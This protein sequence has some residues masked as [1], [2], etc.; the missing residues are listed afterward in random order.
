M[1]AFVRAFLLG[2]SSCLVGFLM[3]LAAHAEGIPRCAPEASM[4]ATLAASYGERPMWLGVAQ[5]DRSSTTVVAKPD[6][7]TWTIIFRVGDG[8]SCIVA[9]GTGWGQPAIIPPGEEG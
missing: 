2:W 3:A 1:K 7:T 5:S 9:T 4:L 8:V 6:G